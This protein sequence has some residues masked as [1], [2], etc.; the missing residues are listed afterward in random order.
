MRPTHS[1]MWLVTVMLLGLTW[2]GLALAADE[3]TAPAPDLGQAALVTALLTSA[4]P[5]FAAGIRWIWGR[6]IGAGP[7]W[8]MPFKAVLAGH[9]VALVSSKLG[10][11]LP[12]DLLHITDDQ[13]L[14]LVTS[15]TVIGAFGVLARDLADQLRKRFG[16]ETLIGRAIRLLAGQEKPKLPAPAAPAGVP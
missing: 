1:L 8:L 2:S 15:G 16:L 9:L 13:V 11:P 5:Y 14:Q 6:L 12:A 3:V 4:V 10:V 7:G